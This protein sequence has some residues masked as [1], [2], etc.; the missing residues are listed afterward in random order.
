M[1]KQVYL[2]LNRNLCAFDENGEQVVEVNR[3]ISW[4]SSRRQTQRALE[5]IIADNPQEIYIS[6]WCNWRESISIE[7]LCSILG[8]GPWY[9]KHYKH[10][11]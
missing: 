9:W 10:D 4:K 11:G 5:R 2:F 1:I 6:S 8:C 3:L 7:I